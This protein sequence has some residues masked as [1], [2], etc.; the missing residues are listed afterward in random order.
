MIELDFSDRTH[1]KQSMSF[2]DKRFLN[3]LERGIR[4][5]DG[6]YEMPITFKGS[7]PTLPNIKA[8]SIHR[9]NHLRKRLRND[10]RYRNDYFKSMDDL[11]TKGFAEKVQPSQSDNEGHV[12]YI[13][14]HGVYHPQK[15]EKVR[16]VFDCSSRVRGESLND[17]LLQDPDSTNSLVGVLCRFR[18][19]PI[20]VV[21]DIEQM[22][23]QF[24]VITE[25]RDYL[26]FLWLDNYE[27]LSKELC[28]HRMNV[29][30]FGAASYPGCTNFGLKQLANDYEA[31][32]G[33][34]VSNFIRRDFYVDD[35]LKSLSNVAES[36]NLIH[37]GCTNPCQVLRTF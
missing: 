13:P 28:E 1:D 12:W 33:S 20:A 26:K 24:K 21:C 16:V 10:A 19:K 36:V 2:D 14:H 25:H 7:E 23:V 15:P 3:I 8:Q 31:H 22:F 9:F 5:N 37:G 29:H 4:V 35:G 34:E 27:D 30:L 18:Q 32:F 17:Y 11:I 6:H